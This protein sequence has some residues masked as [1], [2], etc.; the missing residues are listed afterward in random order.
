MRYFMLVLCAMYT[1][2]FVTT[3][4]AEWRP[5]LPVDVART[6]AGVQIATN[7]HGSAMQPP[8][9]SADLGVIAG[10]VPAEAV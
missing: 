10:N 7:C 9:R 1:S 5:P 6:S 4:L 8:T 2:S 3:S